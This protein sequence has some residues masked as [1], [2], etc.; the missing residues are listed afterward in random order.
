MKNYLDL[1]QDILDNGADHEDRTGTGRRSV[2]GRQLRFKMSDG[3]PLMTTRKI[4]P[5]TLIVELLWFISGATNVEFLKDNNVSIWDLWTPTEKDAEK[6]I[7]KYNFQ[8]N[9]KIIE[10]IKSKVNTIGGIYG[11]SW[12]S[13]S[14]DVTP[15]AL[16]KLISAPNEE[17]VASD[18]LEALKLEY[19]QRDQSSDSSEHT[20]REVLMT[21]ASYKYDQLFELTKSLKNN[22]YSARHIVSAW[23]VNTIPKNDSLSPIESVLSGTGALAPC[24]ILQQYTVHPPLK[25]GSKKRLSLLMYQRSCDVPVGGPFNVSQYSLLLHMIAQVVDM[26]PYEF[27]WTIG[28]AH[29]YLNQLDGVKEQ[30]T[31]TPLP[32]PKLKLNP[33]VKDLFNFKMEDIHIDEYNYLDHIKYKVSV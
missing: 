24:H 13:I 1:M 22:P 2:F 9:E 17:L 21:V 25:E 15:A 16:S 3:F 31:R 30:V 11:A 12:R 7:Q 6:Q 32:L 14:V 33:E 4:I 26:E 27:V 19:A 23:D 8:D 10:Y 28:D 29:I 18:E 20:L 5:K